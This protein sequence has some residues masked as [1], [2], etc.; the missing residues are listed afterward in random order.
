V[1]TP[2]ARICGARLPVTGD[3]RRQAYALQQTT[4]GL[5]LRSV[6]CTLTEHGAGGHASVVRPL[7]ANTA[8][9]LLWSDSTCSVVTRIA[10]CTGP[11]DQLTGHRGACAE[12]GDDRLA[13][14]TSRPARIH[15]AL[16]LLSA[17]ERTS[18]TALRQAACSAILLCWDELRARGIWQ[19]LPA[20][21]RATVYRLIA[22]ADYGLIMKLTRI[23]AVRAAEFRHDVREVTRLWQPKAPRRL[24][25]SEP[26]EAV[27][28]QL[29]QLPQPWL[30]GALLDLH[31]GNQKAVQQALE[32]ARSGTEPPPTADHRETDQRRRLA[33][34][35]AHRLPELPEP[36]Q[37]DALRRISLGTTPLTAVGSARQAINLL[38]V[39]G[40]TDA[41]LD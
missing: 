5:A 36:W 19:R 9:W 17:P 28:Q 14:D 23:D 30:T 1:P 4:S 31:A 33:G 16:G 3:M 32:R 37:I 40:V 12:A 8:V 13:P 38:P 6:M 24:P 11:C 34:I 41:S 27:H 18:T 21:D 22:Q 7:T 25:K 15:E 20:C 35:A 29:A 26:A 10:Y 2:L 39:Y